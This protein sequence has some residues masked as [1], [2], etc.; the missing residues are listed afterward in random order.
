LH[1]AVVPDL[2]RGADLAQKALPRGLVLAD[3]GKE[4]LEGD[5]LLAEVVLRLVDLAHPALGDLAH[6]AVTTTDQPVHRHAGERRTPPRGEQSRTLAGC[7]GRSP[8]GSRSATWC[9]SGGADDE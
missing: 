5:G 3:V 4:D 8:D 9:D 1:D 2:R 6:D 7:Y